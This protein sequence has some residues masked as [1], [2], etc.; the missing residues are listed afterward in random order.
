MSGRSSGMSVAQMQTLKP[1]VQSVVPTTGQTIVITDNSYNGLLVLAP[2]GTLATLT[3]TLPSDA[4]S[5]V[6]Q[7][8][9]IATTKTLTAV[10]INGAGTIFGAVT[11]LVAGDNVAYQKIAANTWSRML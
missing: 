4:N 6:G 8:E 1:P 2:A 7:I 11:T 10:T 3:I 9:R 5:E